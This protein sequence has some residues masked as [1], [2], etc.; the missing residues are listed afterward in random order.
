[1]SKFSDVSNNHVAHSQFSF[2]KGT[3]INNFNI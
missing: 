3:K 1:M 2:F